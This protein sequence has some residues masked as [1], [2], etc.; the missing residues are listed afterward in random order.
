MDV[1]EPDEK[2]KEVV[3]S[4]KLVPTLGLGWQG[5]SFLAGPSYI[6]LS[7]GKRGASFPMHHGLG[8]THPP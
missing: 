1:L 8:T 7:A 3:K 5:A 6:I 2:R 4:Q